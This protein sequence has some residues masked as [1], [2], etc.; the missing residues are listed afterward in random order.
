MKVKCKNCI[1]EEGINIPDF[2]KS[3]KSQLLKIKKESPI[4]AVKYLR[5]NY[6]LSPLESKYIT[7]HINKK[8]GKCNRCN[9]DKLSK[10]YLNCPKCDALNFNWKIDEQYQ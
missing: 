9:F 10:E 5:T 7:K 4:K 8:Y 2:T 6:E 1:P 3:E